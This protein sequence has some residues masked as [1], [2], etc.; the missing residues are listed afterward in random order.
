MV[1]G[2]FN[3][4]KWAK[5]GIRVT[6]TAQSNQ[7][8]TAKCIVARESDP[9]ACDWHVHLSTTT[10]FPFQS[11]TRCVGS[12][13][14]WC[15]NRFVI[16]SDGTRR[17][18]T[19]HDA[20]AVRAHAP[21]TRKRT[22]PS[23]I[24]VVW[25][26]RKREGKRFRYHV[27]RAAVVSLFFCAPGRKFRCTNS[28]ARYFCTGRRGGFV[29]F[30]MGRG[31]MHV[32]WW[33]TTMMRVFC[34]K[35]IGPILPCACWPYYDAVVVRIARA[36][37]ACVPHCRA[38][39]CRHHPTTLRACSFSIRSTILYVVLFSLFLKTFSERNN[40]YPSIIIQ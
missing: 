37:P 2:K 32:W 3:S 33:G 29:A 27:S 18:R 11:L 36:A 20:A 14:Q 16:K 4:E 5:Y 15:N 25:I 30:R 9:V 6:T 23:L 13:G 21:S 7:L 10:S 31:C 17:E 24:T 38:T 28:D 19:T 39:S 26:W 35:I 22:A 40:I 8:T 1:L 12:R 34:S